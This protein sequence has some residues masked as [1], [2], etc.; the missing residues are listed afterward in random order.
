M[1]SDTNVSF[2]KIQKDWLEH[3]QL[4]SASE[5]SIKSYAQSHNLDLKALYN[6]RCFFRKKGLLGEP[7]KSATFL[8]AV[9]VIKPRLAP[10][11]CILFPNNI[12]LEISD[13]D[14]L[15]ALLTKVQSL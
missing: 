1:P 7:K 14:D 5:Q 12:R 3:V 6:Y 9:K 13:C 10:S 15:S 8:K 2:S 4:A 11:V